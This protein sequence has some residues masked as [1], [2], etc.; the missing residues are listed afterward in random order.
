MCQ[1]KRRKGDRVKRG[2]GTRREGTE[3]RGER[4]MEEK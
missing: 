3:R 4:E 2:V 1:W